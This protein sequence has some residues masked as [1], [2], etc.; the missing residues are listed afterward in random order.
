MENRTGL[1]LLTLVLQ[2]G[3]SNIYAKTIYSHI[4]HDGPR[5]TFFLTKIEEACNEKIWGATTRPTA[6]KVPFNWK[7]KKLDDITLDHNRTRKLMEHLHYLIEICISSPSKINK[8][9]TIIIKYRD[10]MQRIHKKDDL[11]DEDIINFQKS[12]DEFYQIYIGML[13]REGVTNYFHLLGSCH[14]ADYLDYY[15]N[16][17]VHSQQGWEA[18]NSFL[19][20]F[21]FRRTNRGGGNGDGSR[22][23]QIARWLGIRLIWIGGATFDEMYEY[24]NT[25]T[26]CKHLD[27]DEESSNDRTSSNNSSSSSTCSSE[28]TTTS[29]LEDDVHD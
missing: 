19:K 9:N 21:F 20:V 16:L 15:R 24:V 10:T 4:S 22:V 18:F 23:R 13:G 28:I 29:E 11:S 27:L 26:S 7:D 8:W 6:W 17:Y 14:M 25:G 12:A 3:I 1:K 5:M 2:E